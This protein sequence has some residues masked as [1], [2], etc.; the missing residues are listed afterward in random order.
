MQEVVRAAGL[1]GYR[2]LVI[3]LGGDPVALLGRA[4]LDPALLDDPDRYISYR[5]VLL[6]FEETARG[7]GVKDFGLRLAARQD[8]TF[9]GALS[10]AI[11]SARSVRQGL[12]VAA[13]HMNFHTPALEIA[14][15]PPDA[16]GRERVSLRFLLRDPPLIP[17]AAEHAVSHL[18]QVVS[19]L[20]DRQVKPLAIAFR[21]ARIADEGTYIRHFGQLPQFG[22]DVDGIFLNSTEARRRLPR[23]NALMQGFVERFLIGVAPS[24]E[25][26]IDDQVRTAMRSLIR[27]QRIRLLD[28]ARVLRLHPRALQ[29]RLERSETNFETLHDEIKRETAEELLRHSRVPIAMV[30][31]IAGFAD[32]PALN[33]ACRRWFAHTPGEIRKQA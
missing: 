4:G 18:R 23:N 24:P 22:S 30:A 12:E 26:A 16:K 1:T 15:A 8:L 21:H 11:Q 7:L 14:F 32:Q 13:R 6:A 27:V 3:E 29:R 10:L 31:K 17:Q 19:V 5:N 9:L 2:R 33:R 25:L 28:V 20:S